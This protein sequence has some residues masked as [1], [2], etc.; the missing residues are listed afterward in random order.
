MLILIFTVQ[1]H[2]GPSVFPREKILYTSANRYLETHLGYDGYWQQPMRN[3]LPAMRYVQTQFPSLAGH[4]GVAVEGSNATVQGDDP[5][6]TNS[7]NNLAVPPMD[8]YGPVTRYFDVFTRGTNS[9]SWNASPWAP[10]VKLSQYNGSTGPNGSDSR[11]FISI[12]WANAP[13]GPN[14]TTVN[15]NITTP[16]RSLD[17][18]GYPAPMVQVPVYL[19]SVPSNFTKGFVESDG[20]IAIEGPHYQAII[21]PSGATASNTTSNSTSLFKRILTPNS[22]SQ[23]R[24]SS[25]TNN[26]TY[27]T[28][29]KYGRTSG[30]VGLWP[31]NTEKLTVSTAPALEYNLYLFSN[32]SAANVTVYLSPSQNYLGDNNPLQYAIALY[33][34]G[35]GPPQKPTIVTPV[36]RTVGANM[37]DGWGYA[38]GDGV[39]GHTG[40]YTTSRFNVTREGA[41]TLRIWALLPSVVVQKVIV[42]M[43]GVRPSYLGPPESFLVG[44]DG[45][46]KYNQTSFENEPDVVGGAGNGNMTRV[47]GD[48]SAAER[49]W[50]VGGGWVMGMMFVLGAVMVL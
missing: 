21:P 26:V 41:Y 10:W 24:D 9:C 7:G 28:F 38:V 39:W 30:G 12:D 13:P 49:M 40:N 5:W 31:L 27:H 11:V 32:S 14:T 17:K 4:V 43:G 42:D 18:Y 37:P 34:S 44:R 29:T 45:A 8:L 16:C 50:R 19:R 33:R 1:A 23:K 47:E 2:D 22:P 48:K 35:S 46:G 15:I 25:S 6:H 36:G 20:H 3:T